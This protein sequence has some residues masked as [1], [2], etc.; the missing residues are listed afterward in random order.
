M[1]PWIS[2]GK[3]DHPEEGETQEISQGRFRN[4]LRNCAKEN[5]VHAKQ[6]CRR[7]H[8]EGG[9][10]RKSKVLDHAIV[11]IKRTRTNAQGAG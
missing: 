3:Y 10:E 4:V 7:T 5:Q 6:V 2:P 8:R 11:K 9:A 1:R